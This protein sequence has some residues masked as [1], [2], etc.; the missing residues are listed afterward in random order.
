MRNAIGKEGAAIALIIVAALAILAFLSPPPLIDSG[1]NGICVPSPNLWQIPPA[2]SRTANIVAI[3]AIAVVAV[4]FNKKLVFVPGQDYVF[5]AL[6]LVTVAANPWLTASLNASTIL[7]AANLGC[8]YL[9]M[10][11]YGRP[12]ATQE[13]FVIATIAGLGA[14]FMYAFVL[15]IPVY[16]I[17]A[18]TLQLMR[19][20]EFCAFGLGL[21]APYWTLIGLGII[22]P[23]DFAIPDIEPVFNSQI[24]GTD[25]AF[26][27]IEL[28]IALLAGLIAVV[29]NSFRL[30]NTSVRLM[31]FNRV[32]C[33][34]GL[35][36]TV[37][38][39]IDFTNFFAY[40]ETILLV[41]AIQVANVFANSSYRYT[42]Y[43]FI[44]VAATYIILFLCI[45]TA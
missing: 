41:V 30:F 38:A 45:L 25:I 2:I 34:C 10:N 11:A 15:F 42:P 24:S 37:F 40:I 32:I 6:F 27:L 36:A 4:F 17:C 22:A 29:H 13:M 33:I 5:P 12:N 26:V 7:C 9:L 19:P 20:K 43:I 44:S 23:A 8:I 3:I 1:E 35:A 16:L 18:S 31:L 14:M 28:G 39:C 21:F